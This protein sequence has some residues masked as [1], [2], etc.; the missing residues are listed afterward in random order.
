MTADAAPG[1]DALVPRVCW[2]PL[3]IVVAI[4]VALRVAALGQP[5]RQDEADT[6]VLFALT[7]LRHILVDTAIPNNHILHTVL[8]KGMIGLFGLSVEVVRFPAFVAGVAMVPL[9]F[10]VA[11]RWYGAHG[12]LTAAALVAVSAPL[13][14]YSTNA[15]GYTLIGA[16]ML[17]GLLAV[18]T[19]LEQ[20]DRRG[21]V[22][23][24]LALAAGAA[25]NPSMLYP[26]GGMVAWAMLEMTRAR[27]G[28]APWR[29][30]FGWSAAGAALAGLWYLPAIKVSGWASIVANDYVTPL[31]W[32]AFG[33]A[34]WRFLGQVGA[35]AAR[36]WPVGLGALAGVLIV[37][38]LTRRGVVSRERLPLLAMMAAWA[39][40]LLVLMRRPPF[41][42]VWL[43]LLPILAITAAAGV[44]V[45]LRGV[46]RRALVAGVLAVATA[47]GGAIGITARHTVASSAETGLIPDAS[48]V[49]A[50]L[51]AQLAT[52]DQVV[53]RFRTQGPVDFYLRSAGRTATFLGDGATVHGRLWVLTTPTMQ[54]TVA[55]VVGERHLS[56]VDASRAVLVAS[57]PTAS[58]WRIEASP[59]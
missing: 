17:A 42:R 10:L 34:A 16:A 55:S 19:A 4:G 49:A 7:P 25:V 43:F 48:R 11:R 18:R 41:L 40:V 21:W 3:A 36:G 6:V 13:V 45:V 15:R 27:A 35:W 52:G 32:G 38:G 2:L 39:F 53:G 37:L 47:L 33:A 29:A 26:A 50:D 8:V 30:F 31:S 14:L 54:E 56:G 46:G 1:S 59:R 58:L 23:W 24:A 9:T 57:Y 22:T 44:E 28:T 20:G 51:S 12:A 5:M